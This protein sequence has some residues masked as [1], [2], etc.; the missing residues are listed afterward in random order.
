MDNKTEKNEEKQGFFDRV[1]KEVHLIEE[2]LQLNVEEVKAK[3]TE[4]RAQLKTWLDGAREQLKGM[5]K[6]G[7]A[8]VQQIEDEA[9]HIINLLDADDELS[10]TEHDNTPHKLTEAIEKFELNVQN[11]LRSAEHLSEE[12]KEQLNAEYQEKLHQ[13]KTQIALKKAFFESNAA[14]GEEVYQ[15]W[16]DSMKQEVEQLKEKVNE[17]T[18]VAE[19]QVGHLAEEMKGAL[20]EFKK[21]FK[22]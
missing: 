20:D 13:F 17:G 10:Y 16:K 1:K 12:A 22:L 2:T 7:E 21:V 8:A 11:V 14:K 4:E 9:T 6:R 15:Q 3:Y 19:E 5:E 18:K